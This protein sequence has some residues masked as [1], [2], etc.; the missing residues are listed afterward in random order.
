MSG[1]ILRSQKN[2]IFNV[3]NRS[4]LCIIFVRPKNSAEIFFINF[5]FFVSLLI[6]LCNFFLSEL[7]RYHKML[8]NSSYIHKV[9]EKKWWVHEAQCKTTSTQILECWCFFVFFWKLKMCFSRNDYDIALI[10]SSISI[11][12]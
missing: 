8:Q 11:F 4:S 2:I 9:K 1:K 6:L 5:Y 7:F 12:H 3:L 10:L